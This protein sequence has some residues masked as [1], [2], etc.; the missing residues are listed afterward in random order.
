[1][2]HIRAGAATWSEGV[3]LCGWGGMDASQGEAP[4]REDG[5]GAEAGRMLRCERVRLSTTQVRRR[6]HVEAWRRH[7]RGAGS[8]VQQQVA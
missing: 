3:G 2:V 7:R 8:V 6:R 4:Q 5:R 1:M